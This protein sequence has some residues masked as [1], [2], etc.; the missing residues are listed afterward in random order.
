MK[1]LNWFSDVNV[2]HRIDLN[3]HWVLSNGF[4][5][6]RRRSR[7]NVCCICANV[8]V[9]GGSMRENALHKFP[10]FLIYCSVWMATSSK[11]IS[12]FDSQTHHPATSES[13]A[14]G[15]GDAKW[16]QTESKY[17]L[18]AQTNFIF[19]VWN[20]GEGEIVVRLNRGR[21]C[22]VVMLRCVGS[23]KVNGRFVIFLCSMHGADSMGQTL[24]IINRATIRP[25]V[26]LLFTWKHSKIVDQNSH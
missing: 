10:R 24:G 3:W 1:R 12:R 13:P 26:C 16:F 21:R 22:I 17:F 8:H 9:V 2:G 23:D 11:C 7:T 18:I 5:C 6:C 14:D 4:C 20:S 25:N 19:C 15:W